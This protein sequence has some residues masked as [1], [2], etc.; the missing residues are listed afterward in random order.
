MA[1][2]PVKYTI[3]RVDHV[4]VR[5]FDMEASRKFWCGILGFKTHPE[6]G[7]W[8]CAP[9]IEDYHIIH[10]MPATVGRNPQEAGPMDPAVHVALEVDSLRNVARSL[11]QGGCKPFQTTLNPNERHYITELEKDS[12]DFGIGTVFVHDPAENYVEFIDRHAGIFTKLVK[13]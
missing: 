7:N 4:G 8:L 12:L 1:N 3:K 2:V 13:Q 9:G 6:K 5:A 10:L 11:L